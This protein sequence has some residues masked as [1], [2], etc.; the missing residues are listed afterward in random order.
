MVSLGERV[1]RRTAF[2]LAAATLSALLV[3]TAT[4]CSRV[5]VVGKWVDRW[6][7]RPTT[8]PIQL[9][10][11]FPQATADGVAFQDRRTARPGEPV[12]VD[13]VIRNVSRKALAVQFPNVSTVEFYVKE[14]GRD[15]AIRIKPVFSSGE[16]DEPPPIL[17]PGAMRHRRFVFT[18]LTR[19]VG[20]HL[21]QAWYYPA[22]KDVPSDLS[23][24]IAKPIALQV[25]GQRFCERDRDGILVKEHAIALARRRLGRPVTDA[26]ARLI[27]DEAGFLLWWVTLT[28]DPKDLKPGDE[29]HRAYFVCPYQAVIK[30]RPARPF[31]PKKT[32][33]AT[34]PSPEPPAQPKAE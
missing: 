16:P 2:V 9:Q 27:P 23:P 7:D 1:N 3:A 29:P 8:E 6:K 14:Q 5:P 18:L 11:A 28:I 4:G 25:E 30:D 26:A 13:A 24:A 22:P 34:K 33:G 17:A 12:Y 21:L 15:E 19:E 10:I 32:E 31:V 20:Q